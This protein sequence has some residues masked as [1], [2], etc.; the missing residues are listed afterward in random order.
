[1]IAEAEKKRDALIKKAID[2]FEETKAS[3]EAEFNKKSNTFPPTELAPSDNNAHQYDLTNEVCGVCC[4]SNVQ[5]GKNGLEP[6]VYSIII[7]CNC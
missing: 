4:D 7:H 1:M 6:C 5:L 3:I 2:E